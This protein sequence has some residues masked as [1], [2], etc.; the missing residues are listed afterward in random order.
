MPPPDAED[1]LLGEFWVDVEQG[2]SN[3]E[4]PSS[5][6]QATVQ[7]GAKYCMRLGHACNW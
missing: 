5:V 3:E 2:T 1:E 4:P 7:A 6:P